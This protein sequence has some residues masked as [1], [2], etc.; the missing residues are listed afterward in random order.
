MNGLTDIELNSE[1]SLYSSGLRF[2]DF[3]WSGEY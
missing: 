3:D 2:A 1:L